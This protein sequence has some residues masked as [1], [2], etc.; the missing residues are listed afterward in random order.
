MD[1]PIYRT[2]HVLHKWKIEKTT[3]IN[4]AHILWRTPKL[5]ELPTPL[6]NNVFDT[7]DLNL[8]APWNAI[9]LFQG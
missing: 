9:S 2:C 6:A 4:K 7:K 3:I 1:R 5:Q 8:G